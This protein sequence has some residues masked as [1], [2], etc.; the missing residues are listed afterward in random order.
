MLSQKRSKRAKA[1][2]YLL[3]RHSLQTL[4]TVEQLQ[5]SEFLKA[6]LEVDGPTWWTRLQLQRYLVLGK[7]EDDLPEVPLGHNDNKAGPSG[8][9]NDIV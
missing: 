8:T 4:K 5:D 3:E 9:A 6:I 7:D 1:M 2:D